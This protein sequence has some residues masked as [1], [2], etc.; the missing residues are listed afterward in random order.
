M[1]MAVGAS[2][3][4]QRPCWRGLAVEKGTDRVRRGHLK[5]VGALCTS[6]DR[7]TVLRW[8][9]G[10]TTSY[11]RRTTA[12]CLP[13]SRRPRSLPKIGFTQPAHF[14]SAGRVSGSSASH[15]LP[16]EERDQGLAECPAPSTGRVATPVGQNLL[17]CQRSSHRTTVNA[18]DLPCGPIGCF[19]RNGWTLNPHRLTREVLGERVDT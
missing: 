10:R 8:S 14:R 11:V 13:G 16:V 6:F 2:A 12:C 3:R 15:G 19:G 5:Q 4:S 18:I 1:P 9:S 7:R 17:A